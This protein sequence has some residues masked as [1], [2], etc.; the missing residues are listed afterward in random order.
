L[1]YFIK[2]LC[3]VAALIVVSLLIGIAYN[4][5]ISNKVQLFPKIRQAGTVN[6][7]L[8]D[9]ASAPVEKSATPSVTPKAGTK[10]ET[11]LPK[12]VQGFVPLEK[13]KALFDGK[14]AVFLDARGEEAFAEGHIPGAMNVP[15]DQ[16]VDYYEVLTATVA[17]D[18][19]VVVYCWSLTC[20]FSDSLASE[21]A[22]MGYTNIVI[23][24]GGWEEWQAAGYPTDPPGQT[25]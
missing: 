7:A 8:S 1:K 15:Y 11:A 23:F 16:L 18:Q 6:A 25:E 22:L 20:D 24:R 12:G 3:G 5:Y 13:A 21:L 2:Q 14:V 19:L 9:T 4:T 10:P 17:T